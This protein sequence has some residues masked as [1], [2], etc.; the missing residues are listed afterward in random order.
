MLSFD[1]WKAKRAVPVDVDVVKN[2]ENTL[3]DVCGDKEDEEVDDVGS[4]LVKYA[5]QKQIE[6]TKEASQ[7]IYLH[8]ICKDF[9]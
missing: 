3:Y 6:F 1:A 4:M 8:K 2:S 9:K 7:G 5:E